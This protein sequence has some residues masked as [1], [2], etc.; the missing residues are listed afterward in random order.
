[1][2]D[3]RMKTETSCGVL[4]FQDRPRRSFLVLLRGERLDLPKGRKKRGENDLAC[5]M[6]EL[7]EETGI[8]Q[9]HI[10]IIDSFRFATSYRVKRFGERIDKTVVVFAAEMPGPTSVVT[11]DHDDYAWIPY[12]PPFDFKDS[13]TI[14]LALLAWSAHERELLGYATPP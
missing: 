10:R 4:L 11:P 6:R 8:H 1:M 7:E 2:H 9:R 14:H 13:P 3:Q 12:R 5:A